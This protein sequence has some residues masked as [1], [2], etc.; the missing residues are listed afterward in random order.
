M[1]HQIHI[2][3]NRLATDGTLEEGDEESGPNPHDLYDAA[4]GPCKA[5]TVLWKDCLTRPGI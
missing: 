5:L 4:L 3:R 1:W 2:G